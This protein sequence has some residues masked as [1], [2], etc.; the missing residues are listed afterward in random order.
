MNTKHRLYGLLPC[1]ILLL[2]SLFFTGQ[3][4]AYDS[5]DLTI[6]SCATAITYGTSGEG[7]PLMAYQFGSGKNVMVLGFEIHGYEDNYNKDGGALVYTAGQLM[8]LLA[9]NQSILED[10]DWTIYVLPSMNPDGLISGYTKDGPGR[11]TT[12]YITSSGNLSY[13]RGIDMNRSFPT[14]WT[15]YTSARN[16]N[17]SAPL[18][19]RESAALAKFVQDVKGSGVNMCFDVHGWFS[20]IITSNGYDNVLYKTLKSAFPSNT[21]ASCRG[22]QGYFTA[23]TTSLGYTSCLFEFPSDVYSFQ[24]YQRS[25]YCEKFNNCILTIAKSYGTYGTRAYT[26]T[27]RTSGGGSGTVSGG[28]AY[29]RG[30][31][32]TLTATPSS[33]SAFTGWYDEQG[34]LLSSD[35][36]YSFTVNSNVTVYAQFTATHKV[37]TK[38]NGSGVVYGGGTY[39]AGSL[40]TLT[41]EASSGHTFIGW[42]DRSNRLLST[43]L[44]YSFTLAAN[45]TVTAQFGSEITLASSRSGSVIGGGTYPDGTQVTL[46]AQPTTDREFQG[47]YTTGGMLLSQDSS[48]T[49][50]AD[51]TRTIVGMFQGDVFYDITNQSWYLD[52]AMEAA[53]RGMVKGTNDIT[54][55]PHEPMTRGQVVTILARMEQADTASA[56]VCAFTDVDQNRYYAPAVNW[57]YANKIVLGVTETRFDPNAPVTRQ[58]LVTI[59]VRYLTEVR[60]LTLESAE[61]TFT[62]QDQIGNFARE[63]VQK[64]V[65]IGLVQ[66][67]KDGSFQPKNQLRRS[68]GVTMLIR[69]AHYLEELAQQPQEPDTETPPEESPEVSPDVSPEPSASPEPSISPEPSASPEP[70]VSPAPSEDPGSATEPEVTPTPSAGT[71][72]TPAPTATP[73]ENAAPEPTH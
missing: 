39:A 59:L 12:S 15:S 2:C 73:A 64:A 23:Y 3:A 50:T 46:T 6:P 69:V 43:N 5:S 51:G 56:P 35:A 17:G 72:V 31:T 70:S 44:S 24:G 68:E 47:W 57:A 8:N 10:Y 52:E 11:L 28:G 14:N 36:T 55:S 32:A 7:R 4:A 37:T 13:S 21:Y 29:R 42:Y 30:T 19:S 53:E 38:A 45:V 1:L 18:A 58:Q 20:Q 63:S 9:Q 27:A 16:F 34:N 26:V 66:G 25:G 48:Y 61:L 49:I 67:Y 71:E 65:A 60:G 41:A 40:V 22:G 33:G 62:D 54:F